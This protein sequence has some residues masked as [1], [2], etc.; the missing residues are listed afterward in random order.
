MLDSHCHLNDEKL[1]SRREEVIKSAHEAG[2]ST[3]LVI[4]WDLESSKKAIQIAHESE[5]IFAAIGL[6]PENIA[7]APADFLNEIKKLAKD[8]KV[9]AIGEIGL[10][11]HWYKDLAIREAQKTWFIRQIDLANEL[12]LPISIH[13]RD[14]SEDTYE[15]LSKHPPLQKGVLHCYSGSPE[16]LRRFAALGMYFGFDGPIT[17]K[18]SAIPKASVVACPSDRLLTETDSPYLT[19]EPNRGKIN[20]PKFLKNIFD[21][22]TLL[23]KQ[24]PEILE[25][26]IEGNFKK[27]FHVEPT[28]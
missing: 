22:M 25:K 16:M 24:N 9:I 4:G 28:K 11:Y 21:E 14:A 10:D 12:A 8:D 27:L 13:A 15:I 3:L 26:Q 7:G 1:F 6:H 20:E 23:R 17:Y 2:V 19:P 5:G 18:G